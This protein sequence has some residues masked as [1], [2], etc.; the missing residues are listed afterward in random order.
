MSLA[1]DALDDFNRIIPVLSR[2]VEEVN[3]CAITEPDL[4]RFMSSLTEGEAWA[5]GEAEDVEMIAEMTIPGLH[6]VVPQRLGEH[7]AAL[8]SAA[9]SFVGYLNKGTLTEAAA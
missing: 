4:F 2:F 6:P 9:S 7:F 3:Y 8:M 5:L 1:V